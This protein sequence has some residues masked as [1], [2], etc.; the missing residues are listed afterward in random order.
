MQGSWPARELPSLNEKT[1]EITSRPTRLYNC[2][3]WSAKENRRNWWP[4]QRGVG[5]WPTARREATVEGLTEAYQT[6]GY[7]VCGDGEFE[8]GIE[9]IAIFAVNAGGVPTPT[10]AALQLISGDWTSKLGSCEDIKHRDVHAVDGP[11]YGTL[12]AY[13][14]PP[15]GSNSEDLV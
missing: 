5:Y 9:K 4:D 14:S 2:L 6:L 10:H 13:M 1:C 7:E 11:L 12:V 15:R 3:A 8:V